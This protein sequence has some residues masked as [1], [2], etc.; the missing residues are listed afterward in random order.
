VPSLFRR[1]I[2]RT[3][4]GRYQVSLSD[5]ERMLLRQLAP[6]LRA[7]LADPD[8]PGLRRLFPPAYGAEADADK[9]EEYARLMQEDLVERHGGALE[10]LEQTAGA[11]E[12][13]LDEVDAWVRALNHLRLVIGTRLDVSED[14]DPNTTDDP[15]HQLYYYLGYLQES[16]VEALSGEG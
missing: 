5:E 14:D 1:P 12:L 8:A 16:V 7:A 11:E 4:S 13:T 9:Q 10:I 2:R 15:G 3:R 6:Q